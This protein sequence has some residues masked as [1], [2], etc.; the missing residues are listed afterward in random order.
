MHNLSAWFISKF[1]WHLLVW[2]FGLIPYSWSQAP[3]CFFLYSWHN[4]WMKLV[5]LNTHVTSPP[6]KG[7]QRL[8]TGQWL[9]I[10]LPLY[11]MITWC[12]DIRAY[13]GYQ[14]LQSLSARFIGRT[15]HW[16]VT[17]ICHLHAR[18]INTVLWSK[19]EIFF[20]ICQKE[21]RA[22][23]FSSAFLE[24]SMWERCALAAHQCCEND[25]EET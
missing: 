19:K 16:A 3:T 14:F 21:I 6:V 25:W 8:L 12:W 24:R 7:L 11:N 20:S 15:L 10:Q 17:G 18:D 2:S 4:W 1:F 13:L 23:L 9:Q 5:N 22:I